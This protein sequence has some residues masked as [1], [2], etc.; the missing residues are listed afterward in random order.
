MKKI[1]VPMTDVLSVQSPVQ[2]R[3]NEDT[4]LLL[5]KAIDHGSVLLAAV[6]DGASTRYP[7]NRLV[8]YLNEHEALSTPA[9]FAANIV[10]NSILTQLIDDPGKDL[11]E[12]L[13]VANEKLRESIEHIIG[14]FSLEYIASL[15]PDIVKDDLRRGRLL[16]PACVVTLIRLDTSRLFLE[17][18]H[19]GDTA[20]LEIQGNQSTL[21][22]TSDQMGKFDQEVL[23]LAWHL[24][25]EK[26]LGSFKEAVRLPTVV[27]KDKENGIRHN[28][29][30]FAGK[31][32]PSQG[33]GVVNGLPELENYVE[34]GRILIDLQRTSGFCLISDGLQLLSHLDESSTAKRQRLQNM[35]QIL[36]QGGLPKLYK[37]VTAMIQSDPDLNKYPRVK[38]QDDATGIWIRFLNDH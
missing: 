27:Q 37:E 21:C 14:G 1:V 33:A 9:V 22:H 34:T 20:L 4:W 23:E 28:F 30:N 31:T 5:D 15:H 3:I 19:A 16:L 8:S 38:M 24:M 32:D 10:R 7:L 26:R 36:L 29:V 25:K 13:I 17:Y 11:K 2:N 6:I 12:T 18:A 35:G